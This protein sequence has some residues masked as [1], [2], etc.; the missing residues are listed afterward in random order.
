MEISTCK[1]SFDDAIESKTDLN[2]QPIN[3]EFSIH[4]ELLFNCQ[5]KKIRI[6]VQKC[7]PWSK[8]D[9]Y[10]SLRDDQD[11]EVVLVQAIQDLNLKSQ[12]ALL[13]ALEA[14]GFCFVVTDVL[15]VE[16][17]FELRLWKVETLQGIRCFQ[18]ELMAWPRELSPG[19]LL[20]Q[21]LAGDMYYVPQVSQLKASGQKWLAAFLD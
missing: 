1:V 15:S 7:F 11:K 3:L 8:S 13:A 4:G 19:S 5:N 2:A 14:S 17:D 12:N 10:F 9:G 21:D 6:R 18:T 16:E 20:I